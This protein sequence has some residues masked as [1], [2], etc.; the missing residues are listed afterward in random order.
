[1][2]KYHKNFKFKNTEDLENFKIAYLEQLEKEGYTK[3]RA[4]IIL[5]RVINHYIKK[6]KIIYF[7]IDEEKVGKNS[8]LKKLIETLKVLSEL[9]MKN[10][11]IITD[12]SYK[13]NVLYNHNKD[14]F[15]YYDSVKDNILS[16]KILED[17][18]KLINIV[19]NENIILIKINKSKKIK[20]FIDGIEDYKNLIKYLVIIENIY[21]NIFKFIN[22]TK[23]QKDYSLSPINDNIDDMV[24]SNSDNVNSGIMR[25]HRLVIDKNNKLKALLD[26]FNKND[27]IINRIK[28]TLNLLYNLILRNI[29]IFYEYSTNDEETEYTELTV[30][31]LNK[32]FEDLNNYIMTFKSGEITSKKLKQLYQLLNKFDNRINETSI[33]DINITLMF[34]LKI[35]DFNKGYKDYKNYTRYIYILH[36][37]LLNIKSNLIFI[38]DESK[39]HTITSAKSSNRSYKSEYKED[40]NIYIEDDLDEY[41]YQDE[42]ENI[43]GKFNE[44]IIR[45]NLFKRLKDEP[46]EAIKSKSKSPEDITS[47]VGTFKK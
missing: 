3:E 2:D 18:K 14:L 10:R 13:T 5:E 43:E 41:M 9:L 11:N 30:E 20:D 12:L 31:T 27:V 16:F 36:T 21:N 32:L 47:I 45:H 7:K 42:D 17:F 4:N 19:Y 46:E 29:N 38:N 26:L 34:D 25:N 37:I 39:L 40:S 28:R 1:M 33:E 6:D 44:Y 35:G 23:F 24:L 8:L 15:E 22:K